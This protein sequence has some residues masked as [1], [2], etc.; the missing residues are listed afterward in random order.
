MTE[1]SKKKKFNTSQRNFLKKNLNFSLQFLNTSIVYR[2]LS[3]TLIVVG[4]L[5]FRLLL[6]NLTTDGKYLTFIGAV[7]ICAWLF[8]LRAG[9]FATGLS[10]FLID[11]FIVFPQSNLFLGE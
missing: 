4:T 5:V 9:I 11:Y 2:L 7:I 1:D 3:S 8:G 6:D 10:L